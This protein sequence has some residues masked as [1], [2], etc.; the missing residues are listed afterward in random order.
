MGV[1]A[2]LK[3]RIRQKG[4]KRVCRTLFERHVFFHWELLW[5][6]RDLTTPSPPHRLRAHPPVT[7]T[8]ITADNVQAFATYFGDRVQTMAELARDGHLGLMYLDA[9]GDAVAFVWASTGDYHDRHYYGCTFA[10]G[11]GEY[12]QFGGEMIR[13]YFGS[14]LSVTA[15]EDMWRLMHAKG[16]RSLV[17]V[18]ETHN[19]AAMKMHVRMGYREQGRVTHIYGLFGR[20]KFSRQTRYQGARLDALRT[21]GV[22][23]P[24]P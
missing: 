1:L 4:F 10:V 13:R 6:E 21:P 7:R 18:V 5:T 16:Y 19:V 17:D 8:L 2:R 23:R 24:R 9:R 22:A 12:F 15:Q 14:E 20:W 3:Q 11:P